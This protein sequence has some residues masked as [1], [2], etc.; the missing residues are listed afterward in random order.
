M[1]SLDLFLQALKEIFS[2]TVGIYI[3]HL[4][5]SPTRFNAIKKFTLQVWCKQ[6]SENHLIS[7]VEKTDKSTDDITKEKI[8]NS[9]IKDTIKNILNWYG[10]K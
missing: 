10:I 6:G 3:P 5:I 4:S 1:K 2:D 8:I 9:M 7:S